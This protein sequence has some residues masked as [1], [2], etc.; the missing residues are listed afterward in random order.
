MASVILV[1]PDMLPGPLDWHC[2]KCGLCCL[3]DVKVLGKQVA[4]PLF[5]AAVECSFFVAGNIDLAAS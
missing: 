4:G 1:P 2:S 5:E 3:D